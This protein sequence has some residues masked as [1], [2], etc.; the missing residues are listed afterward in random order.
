MASPS[1]WPS[2]PKSAVRNVCIRKV[3]VFVT[4]RAAWISSFSTTSTPMP[5]ASGLAAVRIALTRLSP[6]SL[7]N[8]LFG[9]C[10]PTSTTGMLTFRVRLRKYAVSSRVAVPWPMTMPAR[11]GCSATSRSQVSSSACQ[12]G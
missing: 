3:D 9:R 5:R 2:T 1:A 11:S 7:D 6:A 8:A 10:A 12:S 4:S